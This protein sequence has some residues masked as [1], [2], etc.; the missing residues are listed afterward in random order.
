MLGGGTASDEVGNNSLISASERALVTLYQNNNPIASSEDWISCINLLDGTTYQVRDLHTSGDCFRLGL[1]SGAQVD[2][3]YISNIQRKQYFAELLNPVVRV[4]PDCSDCTPIEWGLATTGL[5]IERVRR[6]S[7][8]D[9]LDAR[10]DIMPADNGIEGWGEYEIKVDR[11]R[12]AAEIWDGDLWRPGVDR[13][14]TP[15]TRPNIY[16]YTFE[17]DVLAAGLY[18]SAGRPA[19]DNIRPGV[20]DPTKIRFNFHGAFH[21][22]ASIPIRKDS[23]MGPVNN[24]LTFNEIKVESGATLTIES[25]ADLTFTG[26]LIAQGGATIVVEPGVTLRFAPGKRLIATGTV[27]AAGATFT[28]A[29]TGQGWGGVYVASTGVV[30]LDSVLVKHADIGLGGADQ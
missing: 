10:R 17:D 21:T 27:T 14:L 24:T 28:E 2:E 29:T 16:G 11:G 9:D 30:D 7:D 26:D 22:L 19:I 1:A 5:M 13:Q 25:G 8:L 12:T 15:W 4:S 23:W 20:V 18:A 3:I 6:T